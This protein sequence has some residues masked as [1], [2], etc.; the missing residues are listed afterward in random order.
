MQKRRSGLFLAVA[1][2]LVLVF[3]FSS[4]QVSAAPK[5]LKKGMKGTAIS[6]LQEDLRKLGFFRMAPTGYYGNVTVSAV[7][8]LQAKHGIRKDGIAGPE[9]ISLINKLRKGKNTVSSAKRV[10]TLSR[11]DTDR[12]SYMIP[13]RNEAEDV[14]AIGDTAEIYDIETGLSFKVKR[15]YGYNHADSEALT[16]EDAAIMK[17]I[18]GGSWSWERRAVIVITGGKKMAASMNGMPHAG[19]DSEPA[20]EYVKWR[21]VGYGAGENLDTLKGNGMDGHFCIHFLG[22]KTHGTAKVDP[23]HQKMVKKA[24]EWA[25]KNY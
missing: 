7:K 22:S 10:S 21:S 12:N 9:T 16:K 8:K 4:I 19:V 20:N 17:K 5:V 1:V 6:T 25:E 18:Y 13:W 14:F 15:T 11:G 23:E 24:A 3:A 2:T